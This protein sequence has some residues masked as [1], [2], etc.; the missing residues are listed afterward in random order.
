MKKKLALIFTNLHVQA[1]PIHIF[2]RA[3]LPTLDA[4]QVWAWS[5]SPGHPE[6]LIPAA[7]MKYKNQN[8]CY[9]GRGPTKSNADLHSD[10]DIIVWI[11]FVIFIQISPAIDQ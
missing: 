2:G 7:E 4:R 11:K 1:E 9:C 10:L 5:V 6:L 3:E 8:Q